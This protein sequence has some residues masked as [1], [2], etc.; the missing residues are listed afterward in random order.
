MT[1]FDIDAMKDDLKAT[2]KGEN[3]MKSMDVDDLMDA[4]SHPRAMEVVKS[5]MEQEATT[6]KA[7]ESAPDFTLPWLSGQ[8]ADGSTELTLSDHFG[9]RP[10]A[11]I[12]GS[13]T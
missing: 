3:G 8:A 9:K 6:V 2:L 13:Y 5:L 12:F 11:L 4:M 1:E 7:G 10:V